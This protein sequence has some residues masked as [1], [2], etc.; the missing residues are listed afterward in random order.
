V[1]TK[2]NPATAPAAGSPAPRQGVDQTRR[3]R[4]AALLIAAAPV[5]AAV[6]ALSAPLAAAA[7][8]TGVHSHAPRAGAVLAGDDPCSHGIT[9]GA[10]NTMKA[11][12]CAGD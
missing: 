9:V 4:P 3:S 5:A 11:P 10:L 7:I 1:N 8:S 12:V 2:I 6:I